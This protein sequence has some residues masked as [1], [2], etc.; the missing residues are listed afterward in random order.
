MGN[1][2]EKELRSLLVYYGEI[3]D[4]PDAPKPEDLFGLILTFSYS[5][6]VRHFHCV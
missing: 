5:L 2:L 4:T 3:P 6:Q 1:S